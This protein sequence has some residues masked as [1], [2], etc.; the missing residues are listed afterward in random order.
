MEAM[1]DPD[2]VLRKWVKMTLEKM[3]ARPL[4]RKKASITNQG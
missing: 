3:V 1:T 2:P 4:K